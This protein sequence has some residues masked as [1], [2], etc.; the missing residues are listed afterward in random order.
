MDLFVGQEVESHTLRGFLQ[1][2]FPY[3][4][5]SSPA[6]NKNM[7]LVR[8]GGSMVSVKNKNGTLKISG[9]INTQHIGIALG[10][11]I[12]AFLGLI[13]AFIFIGIVWLTKK[14]DFKNLE[15]EVVATLRE[16]FEEE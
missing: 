4:K 6:L 11:G 16:H 14:N 7:I 9:G 8:K 15:E 13:G 10:I 12:G 1:S 3:Y 5:V 2:K